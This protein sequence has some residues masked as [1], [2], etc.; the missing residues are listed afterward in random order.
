MRH[1]ALV[2][3][4]DE[5]CEGHRADTNGAW[6]AHELT[7]RGLEVGSINICRDDVDPLADTIERV[8]RSADL[9]I[10]S[11]GLG[12]T[13]DDR[14]REAL[15][16][17]A[18]VA[19]VEDADAY[20]AIDACLRGRGITPVVKHHHQAMVPAG[21]RWL[22]NPEGVAP[23]LDC[24]V[25]A[26]RVVALPGVPA[27]LKAM[28]HQH[29]LPLLGESADV[30]ERSIFA[31]GIGEPLVERTIREPLSAH[32]VRVGFYPHHGEVEVRLFAR[33]A[34]AG[35]RVSAAYATVRQALG[36]AAYEPGPGE[37]IEHVVVRRLRERGATIATAE[38]LTGGLVCEMLTRVP[39]A[40]DVLLAGLVSYTAAEKTRLLGVP[41]EL[42][43]E[44]TVVSAEVA[45][46]MAE[47]ARA[48]TGSDLALATTGA[49]GPGDWTQPDGR[50][51]PAG[52]VFVALAQ[53]G[54]GTRT[55]MLTVPA[56][57]V[58]V[59]RR[60]AV[61]ALELARRSG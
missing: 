61:A 19:L 15:A 21:G 46:A 39:G 50:V 44:H 43:L 53:E 40:S 10:V 3:A 11:G 14:T 7:L 37:R 57:R 25:G 36:D 16:Q 2:M 24:P 45:A 52:R 18:G 13:E 29:V 59:R 32:D 51:I 54:R 48:A 9:V 5:L 49:A 20:A 4:G 60:A 27:E 33:G 38:S 30:A 34:D 28:F 8:A 17:A 47:G 58:I 31:G 26:A 41:P 35:S 22:T 42:I 55:R 12:P 56:S 23:G 1:A 6:L